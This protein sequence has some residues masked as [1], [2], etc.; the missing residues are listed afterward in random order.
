MVQARSIKVTLII[1]DVANRA[2]TSN[3]REV[4]K[5]NPRTFYSGIRTSAAIFDLGQHSCGLFLGVLFSLSVSFRERTAKEGVELMSNLKLLIQL[6]ATVQDLY[7][8]KIIIIMHFESWSQ[9][10]C[11]GKRNHIHWRIS[12]SACTWR[13]FW[14]ALSFPCTLGIEGRKE[15]PVWGS[16]IRNSAKQKLIWKSS[17][18][19]GPFCSDTPY[20]II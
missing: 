7:K 17:G 1:N 8:K 13:R 14:L 5:P 6:V 4:L 15:K 2:L 18:E 3:E 12:E 10:T 19:Y 16:L 20:I 11:R 9:K